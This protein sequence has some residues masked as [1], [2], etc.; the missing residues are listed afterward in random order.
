MLDDMRGDGAGPRVVQDVHATLWVAFKHAV[1]E[2]NRAGVRR[3]RYGRGGRWFRPRSADYGVRGS[4][5][6]GQSAGA[7]HP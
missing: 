1:R 2:E 6:S 4:S 7:E 3:V 5:C